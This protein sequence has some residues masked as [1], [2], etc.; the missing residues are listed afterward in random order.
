MDK[1]I[2]NI[3]WLV[4]AVLSTAIVILFTHLPPEV[5]PS[6]LQIHG[7]DKITH[8]T[9]YAVIT[10]LFVL[11]FKNSISLLSALI[12]FFSFSTMGVIDELTQPFVNRVASPID[13]LAD[14]I[15]I[16][17]VLFSFLYFRRFKHQDLPKVE[18]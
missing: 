18:L 11:S 1:P 15:G 16:I 12:L 14:I 13:W 5:I 10:L 9:A 2:F 3:K 7:L 4:I 17:T 6:G 8:F